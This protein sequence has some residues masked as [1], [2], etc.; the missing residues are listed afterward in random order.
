MTDLTVIIV[1]WNTRRL[2]HGCLTSVFRHTSGISCQVTVVDNASSDGSPDMVAKAFP[3]VRLIRNQENLGFSRANNQALCSAS[4]RYFLLLNSDTA[5]QDNA[6]KEIVAFMDAHSN[7]GISGTRLLNSD[8]SRQYSCDLFPRRP[9]T[10]LFDKIRDRFFPSLSGGWQDRMSAWD[11]RQDFLV[12]YVI[13]A[14]L[15]IRRETFEQIGLLDERFF[16]YAEDIDWCFR[17]ARAGWQTYYLGSISI[18]HYNR[19]SSQK[20][21][22]QALRLQ[23]MRTHSLRKFYRKHYGL[24]DSVLFSLIVCLKKNHS[25]EC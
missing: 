5:L 15:C 24:L 3:D 11:F 19:G 20:T 22:G 25:N 6:F 17:A 8:G 21:P 10:I 1:N 2:L 18:S 16:M 13:G 7:A 4:S 9:L 12:D 14:V 23:Q